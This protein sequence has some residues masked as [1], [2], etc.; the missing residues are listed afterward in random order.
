MQTILGSSGVIGKET[1]RELHRN[2]TK[3]IRLISRDP[4]AVNP[5]DVLFKADL[6]DEKQTFD[7]VKGSEVDY[8]FDSSKFMKAFRFEPISYH[9]GITETV[10]FYKQS[11]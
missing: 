8:V 1:A 2:Y 4:R 5:T 10:N 6:T 3:D 7:A 9:E 11:S